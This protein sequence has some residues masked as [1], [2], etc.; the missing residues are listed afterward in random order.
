MWVYLV[1][2]FMYI[3]NE[4]PEVRQKYDND[5]IVELITW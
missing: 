3:A 2:I 5:F 4:F 1:V